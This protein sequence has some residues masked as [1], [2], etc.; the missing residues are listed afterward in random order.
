MTATLPGHEVYGP[1][2]KRASTGEGVG[3]AVLGQTGFRE[4]GVRVLVLQEME[5]RGTSRVWE[6]REGWVRG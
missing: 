3:I 2:E 5:S 1:R 6:S 4:K